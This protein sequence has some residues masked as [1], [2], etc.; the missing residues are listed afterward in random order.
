[1][2]DTHD[3]PTWIIV[4]VRNWKYKILRFSAAPALRSGYHLSLYL[5]QYHLTPRRCCRFINRVIKFVINFDNIYK[6]IIT[7]RT[8]Y[9][10]RK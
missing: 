10:T 5:S 3:V 1:M 9:M 8:S 2:H 6:Q 4:A 7:L